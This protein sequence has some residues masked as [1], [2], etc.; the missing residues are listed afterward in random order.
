MGLGLAGG[1][2]LEM[3]AV[4][5]SA[6]WGRAEWWARGRGKW[7]RGTGVPRPFGAAVG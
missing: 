1:R 4:A 3:W 7:G 5:W 2:R 6:E